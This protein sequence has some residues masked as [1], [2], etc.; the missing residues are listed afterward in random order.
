MFSSVKPELKDTGRFTS[1]VVCL[2]RTLSF[3]S[4]FKS[5]IL[6][7]RT[8]WW[9]PK[10]RAKIKKVIKNCNICKVY[11]TKPYGV[12]STNALAEFRTEGS[13]PFKVTGL[14][15]AGPFQYKI[16]KKE[17]AKCCV[18]IFTCASSRAVHLKVA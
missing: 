13:R 8:L 12:L 18:I 15:I 9:T 2:L 5:C 10:L 6:V 11:S 14:D 4:T 16:G 3:I 7:L 17:G 1:L